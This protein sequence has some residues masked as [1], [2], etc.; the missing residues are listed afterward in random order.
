MPRAAKSPAPPPVIHTGPRILPVSQGSEAWHRER[1]T[2]IGGSDANIIALASPYT[3]PFELFQ[4]RTGLRPR[5]EGWVLAKG[6]R[7][8]PIIMEQYEAR[9]GRILDPVV[10]VAANDWQIAS[11]DGRTLDGD[12]IA[13]A[14]QLD[15]ESFELA[16]TG[17][18]PPKYQA[19]V[20]H[21][22][23]VSG[24]AVLDLVCFHEATEEAR[25]RGETDRLHVLEVTPDA[26]R[27]AAL[28][29]LEADFRACL[30]A[31]APPELTDRDVVQRDDAA[32]RAAAELFLATKRE[33][34]DLEATLAT[35]RQALIDLAGIHNARGCGA[36]VTFA[37]RAGNVDWKRLAK[38]IGVPQDTIEVYRG[39]RTAYTLVAAERAGKAVL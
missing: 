38:D 23:G 33:L 8:E 24:A 12:R 30:L 21:N 13:E 4:I 18:V 5:P 6:H 39:K 7:L 25:K 36:F 26:A 15:R 27:F 16:L 2:R 19:Q 10:M 35:Q 1:S 32:W 34:E 37:S 22:L 29:K 3:T 9:T 14:K 20:E 17:V 11:L 31:K 28:T